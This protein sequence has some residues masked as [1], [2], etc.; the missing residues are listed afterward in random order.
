M[1]RRKKTRSIVI[2]SRMWPG[3]YGGECTASVWVNGDHVAHI[4]PRRGSQD[5]AEQLAKEWLAEHG[6]LPGL[7]AY[8]YGGQEPLHLWCGRTGCD[9]IRESANVSRARDL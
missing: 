4:G 8:D 2:F 5:Y 7:E 3:T 1:G 9:L 6:Y